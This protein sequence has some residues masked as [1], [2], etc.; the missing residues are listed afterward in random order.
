MGR[1]LV[2]GSVARDEVVSLKEP[3][4]IGSHLEAHPV[5]PRLGGGGAN[6]AIP[7]AHAGHQALLLAPLGDDATGRELLRELAAEGVDTSAL[8]FVSGPSTRSLVLLEP[9]GERTVV[10]LYR[11]R[12]A[13]PPERLSAL[14][15]DAVYVR[16]RASDLTPW[17]KERVDRG[18]VVAQLPPAD[19]GS[20]PAQVLIASASDFDGE[21][22][23]DPWALGQRVAGSHLR[24]VVVTRGARGAEA[25]SSHEHLVA[26]PPPARVVDTTGAGDAFAAGLLHALVSGDA[27]A[28]ALKTG[29]A[30]GTAAVTSEGS[31]LGRDTVD[32]LLAVARP[33][34]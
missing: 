28:A 10:N 21:R 11:C 18:L 9:S 22:L 34:P 32:S 23:A 30:W 3:L 33:R 7:L 8:A 5:R 1:I 31:F 13:M 2:V 6:V 17:L 12:Q 27:M 15:T 14:T 4:R 24:W 20:R 25:F 19:A 16:S 26:T 29:V